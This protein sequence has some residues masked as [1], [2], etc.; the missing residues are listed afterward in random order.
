[1]TIVKRL[2]NLWRLSEYGLSYVELKDGKPKVA[3]NPLLKKNIFV[4]KPATII[5]TTPQYDGIPTLR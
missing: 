3:A 5:N 1:M 4:K 2:K